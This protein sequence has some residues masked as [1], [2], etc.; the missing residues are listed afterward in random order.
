MLTMITGVVLQGFGRL[1]LARVYVKTEA[2]INAAADAA[3]LSRADDES[4]DN[5]GAGGADG[6]LGGGRVR[7]R[8][9]D[10]GV[11][12]GDGGDLSHRPRDEQSSSGVSGVLRLN[13]V[14]SSIGKGWS[15]HF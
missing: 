14:S 10:S 15:H 13:G 3:P 1:L 8:T 9:G 4:S 11:G 7:R 2:V 5:G 6:G 12:D